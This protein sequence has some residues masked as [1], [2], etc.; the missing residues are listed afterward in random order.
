MESRRIHPHLTLAELEQAA[1]GRLPEAAERHLSTCAECADMVAARALLA[2]PEAWEDPMELAAWG[3]TPECLPLDRLSQVGTGQ[4]GHLDPDELDHVTGCRRCSLFVRAAAGRPQFRLELSKPHEAQVRMLAT[5]MESQRRPKTMREVA[6]VPAGRASRSHRSGWFAA[7]AVLLAAVGAWLWQ[8]ELRPS[9]ETLLATAYTR[10]RPFE[11]RMPDAGYA[12]VQQQRSAGQSV[13]ARPGALMEA[14]ELINEARKSAPET[15]RNLWLSG[16]VD[17]L[18]G[19]YD[20]AIEALTRAVEGDREQPEAR[21]ALGIAYALRGDTEQRGLDYGRAADALLAARRL[22]PSNARISFNLA[23]VYTRM[24]LYKEALEAWDEFLNL[25]RD[26]EWAVEARERREDLA[27]EIELHDSF[28]GRIDSDP[29]VFL[30]WVEDDASAIHADL[31]Y[32]AAWQRWLPAMAQDRKAE[33]SVRVLAQMFVERYGDA[34]LND[35]LAAT[36]RNPSGIVELAEAERRAAEGDYEGAHAEARRAEALLVGNPAAELRARLVGALGRQR[37]EVEECLAIM[38]PLLRDLR[39]SSYVW[40]R[41]SA[42][43]QQAMCAFRAE[44]GS[45]GMKEIREAGRMA[46]ELGFTGLALKADAYAVN[47]RNLQGDGAGIWD[48]ALEGMRSAWIW[49]AY[50]KERVLFL[51]NLAASAEK[52]NLVDLDP[53][54][55]MASVRVLAKLGVPQTEA[56]IRIYAAAA[57]ERAG[58]HAAA[59]E[60]VNEGNRIFATL[61]NTP[62]VEH[63]RFSAK[64]MELQTVK[65]PAAQRVRAFL[66][67]EEEWTTVGW[68]ERFQIQ[69][70]IGKALRELGDTEAAE[71]AFQEALHLYADR[72]RDVQD[73]RVEEG[74][75][76]EA[77]LPLVKDLIEIAVQT[78]PAHALALWDEYRPRGALR[79]HP[80]RSQEAALVYIPLETSLAVFSVRG[81]QVQGQLVSL[82]M[83][84]LR[85]VA[86]RLKRLCATANTPIAEIQRDS[87]LLYDWLIAPYEDEIGDAGVLSIDAG[88]WM[89]SLP[90]AVLMDSANH[91]LAQDFTLF[92]GVRGGDALTEVGPLEDGLILSAPSPGGRQASRF[93]ALPAAGR[94]TRRVAEHFSRSQVLQDTELTLDSLTKAVPAARYLHFA[95]HGWS[96]GGDGGLVLPAASPMAEPVFVTAQELQRQDWHRYALVVLSACL[97]GT[98]ERSGLANRHSLVSAFL[99]G[100]V[101]RVVASLWDADSE[102]TARLMDHFYT[103]L[104]YGNDAATALTKARRELLADGKWSHPYYWAPFALYSY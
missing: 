90:F 29:A 78:D 89:S 16:S 26:D 53:V 41:A 50:E 12:A 92:R 36:L 84:Q 64:L 57:Y 72:L 35:A 51:A 87:R 46:R 95:G 91:Y 60:Q 56:L 9:P 24:G 22:A 4:G 97:S 44:T 18:E 63:M 32:D 48:Q 17:L 7:A 2:R 11:F 73:D 101:R 93:P 8:Q 34:S 33:R 58:D 103:S 19:Q 102:A 5:Q 13:L 49:C 61:D 27:R 47:R 76:R 77:A 104:A 23:L 28:E 85:R 75:T 83:Q 71:A 10:S 20:P 94:E 6:A 45:S 66:T 59:V 81:E 69:R 25:N 39:Q 14:E 100:G 79:V 37:G 68:L 98:G 38:Q 86:Q 62:N 52:L 65:L 40:M 55:H 30:Q 82:D 21:I 31:F 67:L 88:G 54:L 96:N 42:D 15:A 70:E 74:A 1:L 43:L 99:R 80:Q 3:A